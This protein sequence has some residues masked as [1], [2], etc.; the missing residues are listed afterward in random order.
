MI[1]T[2]DKQQWTGNLNQH[3]A[4]IKLKRLYAIL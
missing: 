1:V 4:R 3:D 2:T